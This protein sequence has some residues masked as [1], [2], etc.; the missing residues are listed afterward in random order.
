M[1]NTTLTDNV[2]LHK[3]T[4]DTDDTVSGGNITSTGNVELHKCPICRQECTIHSPDDPSILLCPCKRHGYY[5][6]IRGIEGWY[7]YNPNGGDYE[8]WF[9]YD[10]NGKKVHFRNS[11][12]IEH[13]RDENGKWVDIKPKNWK[14]EK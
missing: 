12:G 7:D 5:K 6:G 4:I 8:E 10:K 1:E 3:C 13:W 9:D 14:Y 11:A 2:E